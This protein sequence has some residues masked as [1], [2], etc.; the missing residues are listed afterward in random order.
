MAEVA[1][2]GELFVDLTPHSLANGK[3]LYAPCPGGAPGN[4]AVGMALL[5]HKSLMISRVGDDAFGMLLLETLTDFGVDTVGVV[6][7]SVEKTGLSVVTLNEAGDRSFMFYHDQPADLNINQDDITTEMLAGARILHVG[8]L[9]LSAPTSAAAQRKALDLADAQ[10]ALI[11]CD[12]NFRP[13]LWNDLK[14]MAAAG[15]EMI[16]R[17][18]IVKVSEA[19]LQL[20]SGASDIEDAVHVLWHDKLILF[21]VTRGANGATLYSRDGKHVCAGFS[22]R[23]V[24]TTGAGDAYTASILSGILSGVEP[25]RLVNLACAAGALAAT[26]KGAMQSLPTAE[27]VADMVLR[28][29]KV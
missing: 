22:V 2:L 24:D 23:A 21:S 8:V 19:E 13:N 26:R 28:K 14:M 10:S 3:W 17:A 29:S 27:E 9:P 12:V 6:L 5:G 11:S 4:V 25:E 15:R 18:A 16:S 20:L 1:C 7:S